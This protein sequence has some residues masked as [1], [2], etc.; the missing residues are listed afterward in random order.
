MATAID[1]SSREIVITR[2]VNA[3]RTLVWKAWTTPEH[4]AKWWG[5]NGFST[6]I[7]EMDVRP[8][9]VWSHTMHGPDGANY[10]NKSIFVEVDEP[11]RI[12]YKHAGGREEGPGAHFLSTWTF[13]EQDGKTALTIHLLFDTPQERDLVV[14]EFG[15]IEGGKQTLGRLDEYVQSLV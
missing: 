5:P 12:V 11:N 10:P 6:T 13:E 7:H 15:A 3:P 9:G 2:V 14:R 1:T 8:G 4:V